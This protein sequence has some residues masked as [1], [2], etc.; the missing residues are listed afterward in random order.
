MY[1]R[2]AFFLLFITLASS[3]I[4]QIFTITKTER[5]GDN[6]IL[7]Y[8]LL[9]SVNNRAYTINVYSSADNYINPLNKVSG[10]VG[11]EVK[12]GGNRKIIWR[13]K[14]ELGPDFVGDLALEV[15]GKIYIPFVKLDGFNDYKK[16][17]RLRN[18][19]ITWTGGRGNSVLNFDLYRGE[20]KIT[21]FPNI[22]N[23]G[24]YTVKFE[25]NIRP[26]NNYKLKVADAKNKDDV[27]WTEN[28]KISRK[29]PLLLKVIPLLGLGYLA[30]TLAGN[31]STNND[32]IDA[33]TPK[34]N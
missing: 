32:I 5:Q 11:L 26:G 14:E 31:S 4:A 22:A 28:F 6:L 13:A 3:S 24:Q 10:D 20:K 25:G 33:P 8:D 18:Y 17:K 27:V 21:S 19:K 12:P 23:V 16:F 15:R 30:T 29:T 7:Y 9:D 34:G 2:L 1:T